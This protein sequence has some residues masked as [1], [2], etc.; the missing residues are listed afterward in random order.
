M[1]PHSIRVKVGD[2][3]H[4]GQVLGLVGNTGNSTEPHLHFHISNASSPLGSEGLPYYF[5]SF[6]VEGRAVGLTWNPSTAKGAPEKH[7]MEI[8]LENDVVRFAP[9]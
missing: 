4:R 3:V 9:N 2:R 7:T 1:L 8:P 6:E 5:R